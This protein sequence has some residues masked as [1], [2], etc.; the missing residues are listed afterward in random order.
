MKKTILLTFSLIFMACAADFML[1]AATA[2]DD[3]GEA[4]AKK[5][6]ETMVNDPTYVKKDGEAIIYLAGGCFWG[7]EKYME[8]IPGVL[9]AVSGYAN[10]RTK[11]RVSY[12]QLCA[13]GTGYKE[14]VRVV[15]DPSKVSLETLLFAFFKV[16]DPSVRDRQGNDVGA[17]YQT[18]VFY[19]DAAAEAVV[20]RVAEIERRRAAGGFYVL[21]EP[22]RIFHEAEEYH[23]NY[24]TKHPNGYCHISR[25]EMEEA[26]GIKIDAAPYRKPAD[27]ELKKRLTE[28]QYAVTQKNGTEPPFDNEYYDNQERGIYVDVVTG[29]PLFSSKD[30]Y[31]SSC[32]WPAFTKGLD[33]G[34][35]VYK[36]DASYGMRRTEVRSRA[37][38][39]HLGHVFTGDRESPNGVRYCINSAALRFIPYEEMDKEGYGEFKKYVE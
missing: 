1:R 23:Q 16:V 15:Y 7:M 25:E 36:E 28:R 3:N 31:G 22:L 30:K 20:R 17:Q 4:R 14:T 39:S 29:E 33:D 24:L 13:G 9:D 10:G 26:R 8:G 18:G 37:G 27:D 34:A 12:E 11:E 5:E 38:D 6:R 19:T 35:L 2:A 32:G 21:V